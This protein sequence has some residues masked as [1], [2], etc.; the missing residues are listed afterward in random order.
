MREI[1]RHLGSGMRNTASSNQFDAPKICASVSGRAG[2][3]GSLHMFI[4][5]L[6]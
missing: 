3:Q 1:L 2:V 4:S 6:V 5:G